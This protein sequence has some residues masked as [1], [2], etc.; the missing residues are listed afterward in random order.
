M[1]RSFGFSD[2]Y[3][4]R[5]RLAARDRALNAQRETEKVWY[6]DGTDGDPRAGLARDPWVVNEDAARRQA[7][8]DAPDLEKLAER[9]DVRKFVDARGRTIEL[10][11]DISPGLHGQDITIYGE[12]AT[13]EL[14]EPEIKGGRPT[15]DTVQ[16]F[17]T[18]SGVVGQVRAVKEGQ[19]RHRLI[20][21]KRK[22]YFT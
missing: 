5:D 17:I 6:A 22:R 12:R 2:A 3:A 9:A 18:E 14:P 8:A 4:K 10:K 15:G 19:G 7:I 20:V 16:R 21:E 11:Q 13:F 1:G